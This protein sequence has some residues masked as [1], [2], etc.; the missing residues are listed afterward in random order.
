MN[1]IWR[2]IRP[3]AVSV[4][5]IEFVSSAVAVGKFLAHLCTTELLYKLIWILHT[6]EIQFKMLNKMCYE[7]LQDQPITKWAD[8]K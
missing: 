2:V 1:G 4:L 7:L 5:Y 3:C 6:G 8:K